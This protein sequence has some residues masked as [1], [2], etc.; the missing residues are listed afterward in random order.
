MDVVVVVIW[1]CPRDR[2]DS[3]YHHHHH[4]SSMVLPLPLPYL[5]TFPQAMVLFLSICFTKDFWTS[6][7]DVPVVPLLIVIHGCFLVKQY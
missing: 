7:F 4:E 6:L 1:Q 2:V 5:I 3:H